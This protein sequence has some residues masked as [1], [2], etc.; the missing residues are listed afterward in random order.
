MANIYGALKKDLEKLKQ[1]QNHDITTADDQTLSDA[2]YK[3]SFESFMSELTD[4]SDPQKKRD[5]DRA[6]RELNRQF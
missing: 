3:A 1:L 5:Y 2:I 6:L 4:M